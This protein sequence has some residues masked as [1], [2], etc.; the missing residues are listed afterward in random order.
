MN[1]VKC[2]YRNIWPIAKMLSKLNVFFF[3]LSFLMLWPSLILNSILLTFMIYNVV[4]HT[5]Y[6]IEEDQNFFI[7]PLL[8]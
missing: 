1:A 4:N 7:P 3:P 8:P 6:F 2:V 5:V